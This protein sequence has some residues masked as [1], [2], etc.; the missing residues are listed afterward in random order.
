MSLDRDM[1]MLLDL[2]HY[3]LLLSAIVCYSA[4]HRSEGNTLILQSSA[5]YSAARHAS[6]QL[7][8]PSRAPASLASVVSIDT[9]TSAAAWGGL[10]VSVAGGSRPPYKALAPCVCVCVCV[11]CV[12]DLRV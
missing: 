11:C 8:A 1:L 5:L 10:K 9:Q 3:T 2:P 12:V 6:S 7:R 4:T